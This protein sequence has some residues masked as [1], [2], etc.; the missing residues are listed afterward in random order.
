MRLGSKCSANINTGTY[1]LPVWSPMGRI[2][3]PKRSQSRTANERVYREAENKKS[4]LGKKAYGFSFTYIPKDVDLTDAILDELQDSFD[5]GTTLDIAIL[6]RPAAAG[7]IGIR[8]PWQVSQLDRNE[9][10]EDA[11]SYDVVIVEVDEEQSGAL[12]EVDNYTM[13]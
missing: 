1:A 13:A 9:D 8:G 5:N 4:I 6:D 12:W 11:V 7:A 3:S 2:S 10:D